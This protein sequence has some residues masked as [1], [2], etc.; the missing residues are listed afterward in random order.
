MID[1]QVEFERMRQGVYACDHGIPSA[2]LKE[3]CALIER[4]FPGRH[5][6]VIADW[7]WND[8]ASTETDLKI[9]AVRDVRP[10]FLYSRNILVDTE[11]RG[12]QSVMTSLMKKFSHNAIFETE[13]RIYLLCGPGKRNL[14]NRTAYFALLANR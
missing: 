4:T 1:L 2:K 10:A 13:N 5:Y 3:Y 9:L 14:M 6:C 11:E 7:V 12:F 8:I